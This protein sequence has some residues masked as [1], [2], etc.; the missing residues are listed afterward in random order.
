M[1][2]VLTVQTFPT[3]LAVLTLVAVLMVWSRCLGHQPSASGENSAFLAVFHGGILRSVM[4]LSIK[5]AAHVKRLV[6]FVFVPRLS[7]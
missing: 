4:T 1:L 7:F 5:M 3:V 2:T 6:F